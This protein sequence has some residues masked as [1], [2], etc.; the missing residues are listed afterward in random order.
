MKKV[1]LFSALALAGLA[2]PQQ[3]MAEETD[4]KKLYLVFTE[5]AEN[6]EISLGNLS[7]LTKL[8][9]DMSKES[10]ILNVFAQDGSTQQFDLDN[11]SHLYFSEYAL[12]IEETERA[13]GKN[14]Y[15]RNGLL[16]AEGVAEDTPLFIYTTDGRLV[17]QLTLGSEP[18]SLESL[19]KGL[20]IIRANGITLK[21]VK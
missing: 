2:L 3:T 14:M 11:V 7:Q 6:T 10:Q 15:L 4:G 20:Y 17:K 16:H 1:F 19:P 9:F 21:L 8:T 5:R 13:T 18:L 12:S